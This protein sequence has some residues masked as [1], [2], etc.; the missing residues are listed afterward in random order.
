ME[1]KKVILIFLLV[2]LILAKPSSAQTC[3]GSYT[4][5]GLYR[6]EWNQFNRRFSC[7]TDGAETFPCRYS[8]FWNACAAMKYVPEDC[9]VSTDGQ[10]CVVYNRYDGDDLSSCLTFYPSSTPRPTAT[11]FP[12]PGGWGGCGSCSNCNNNPPGSGNHPQNECV[13]D[14]MGVC[15]WDPSKCRTSGG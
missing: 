3:S 1:T 5:T 14:P 2:S 12:T 8:H 10:S 13:L 11:P 9:V 15:V 7:S 6:C 4:S